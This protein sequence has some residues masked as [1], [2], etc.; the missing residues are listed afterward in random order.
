MGYRVYGI[1][2]Y[3]IKNMGYRDMGIWGMGYEGYGI[4]MVY[5]I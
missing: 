5:G 1:W 4:Y 2:G 3:G